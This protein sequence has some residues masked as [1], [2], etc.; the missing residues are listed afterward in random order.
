MLI[1]IIKIL[2]IINKTVQQHYQKS[3]INYQKNIHHYHVQIQKF[4]RKEIQVQRLIL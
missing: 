3:K 1:L 4:N 2:I